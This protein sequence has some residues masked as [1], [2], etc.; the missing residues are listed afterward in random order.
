MFGKSLECD[1][2]I[3]TLGKP[4]AV[5][6][7]QDDIM[8]IA[9]TGNNRVLLVDFNKT[10][11]ACHPEIFE[12]R[13]LAIDKLSGVVYVTEC[14]RHVVHALNL[15]DLQKIDTFG[16]G[17]RLLVPR[18]LALDPTGNNL[19]VA[20]SNGVHVIS[21]KGPN[22][23]EIIVTLDVPEGVSGRPC[24]V[25]ASGDFVVVSY[26]SVQRLVK[27]PVKPH[28]PPTSGFVLQKAICLSKPS[29]L[30]VDKHGNIVVCD[31]SGI[32]IVT[33]EGSAVL[34]NLSVPESSMRAVH[35]V[36]DKNN[37][38]IADELYDNIKVYHKYQH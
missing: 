3:L 22:K 34:S 16:A 7:W 17:G 37:L 26:P 28:T 13:G 29:G 31:N 11:L 21:T 15:P 33:S 35:A 24:G 9:D 23:G 30:S 12:P 20:D 25:G 18:A 38:F 36:M 32:V 14:Y 4:Q 19:Y 5:A 10:V 6:A 27:Y 8:V 1:S 2:K